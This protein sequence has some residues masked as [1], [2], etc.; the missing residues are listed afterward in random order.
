MLGLDLARDVG[1]RVG[2]VGAVERHLIAGYFDAQVGDVTRR[3]YDGVWQV[4]GD[5]AATAADIDDLYQGRPG[6]DQDDPNR[7][8]ADPATPVVK[9]SD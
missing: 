7:P 9:G 8:W 1:R 4:G 3:K 2:I 6:P 5:R